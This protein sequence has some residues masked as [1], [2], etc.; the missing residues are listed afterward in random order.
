[1]SDVTNYSLKVVDNSCKIIPL[2]DKN[3]QIQM[4]RLLKFQCIRQSEIF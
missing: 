3:H 2:L 4:L 1:M